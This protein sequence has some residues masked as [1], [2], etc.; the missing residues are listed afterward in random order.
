MAVVEKE[1]GCS[2]LTSN[3]RGV[4]LNWRFWCSRILAGSLKA[5]AELNERKSCLVSGEKGLDE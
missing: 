3:W 4:K 2:R 1:I 5:N